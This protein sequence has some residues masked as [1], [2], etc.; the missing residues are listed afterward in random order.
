[1]YTADVADDEEPGLEAQNYYKAPTPYANATH[2]AVVEVDAGTGLVKI[3]RYLVVEDCGRMINPMIVEGQIAGGVAQGIGLA[4]Y[5]HLLYDESGQ[6]LTTSLMDYLI[7]TAVDVPPI[8]FGH[9]ETPC[10]ISVGGIKGM[11]EGGAVAP[12]PAIANAICDALSSF[13]WKTINTLPMSPEVVHA[14][15]IS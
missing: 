4:M 7:P 8:E 14:L 12:P 3:V 11:G 1:V 2:V 13:G 9:I 10:P 6:I 5:E 15:T